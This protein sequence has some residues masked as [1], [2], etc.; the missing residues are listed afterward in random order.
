MTSGAFTAAYLELVPQFESTTK[1]KI[2]TLA[3]S[4]GTG[5]GSIPSRLQRGE[6]TDVVIVDDAALDALIKDGRVLSGS[7]VPLARSRHRYGGTGRRTQAG[8]QFGRSAETH[9]S[10]SKIH[11]VL[12]PA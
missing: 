6:P 7:K 5:S 12:T 3:T 8:H 1:N 10:R 4:M 11:R 2:V 9:P